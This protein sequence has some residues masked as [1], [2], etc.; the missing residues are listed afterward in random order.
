MGWR[1]GDLKL[2]LSATYDKD[3]S[4]EV[5]APELNIPH[6]EL[7]EI[8]KKRLGGD[9]SYDFANFSFQSEFIKVSLERNIPKVERNLDFYYATLGYNFTEAFFI[10]G[11]YWFVD[12]RAGIPVL[13]DKRKEEDEDVKVTTTGASYNMMDRVRLK[14]QFSRIKLDDELLLLPEGVITRTEEDFSV[15]GLAV[16]VFF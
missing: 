15:F 9:L 7:S 11:S 13:P 10:Y 5:L 8:P 2:G 14:A 6:T 3:N 12:S 1:Y 4:A 16:S